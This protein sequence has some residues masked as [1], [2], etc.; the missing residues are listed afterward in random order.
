[1][2]N[3]YEIPQGSL[4][5]YFSNLVKQNGGINLA[6]GI[7]GYKPPEELTDILS[8][9]AKKDIHQYAP[10][11]GN[12]K[13]LELISVMDNKPVKNILIVQGATEA[14]VLIY[15]YLS[16]K[17]DKFNVMSFDP[18][19]ESYINL[20]KIFNH[21]YYSF[22]YDDNYNIDVEKLEKSIKQNN[23]KLLMISSPGNPFGKAYQKDLIKNILTLAEKYDFY[24][25]FDAVYRDLYFNNVPYNP[26]ELNSN[27]LFYINSFSKMFSITGWRIGYLIADDKHIKNI[28]SIHDYIGLCA[29][30]VLQESIA[31]YISEF[32]FGKKYLTN[33]RKKLTESFQTLSKSLIN[34]GFKIPETDGGYFIW[35]KLTDIYPDG[36]SFAMDLYNTQK[37]ACIPGIHFSQNGKK[38]I[39]WNIARE[40][41]EIQEAINRINSFIIK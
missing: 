21:N 20:P 29:P 41:D 37:V 10:G 7:P 12:A 34:H 40:I 14:I 2:K 8:K 9:I 15:I 36:F 38:L 31:N 17:F 4:I 16:Q 18:A 24:I 22:N 13:L 39:R 3:K 33:L 6:Q 1:M 23:I 30:S 19:Y 28:E 26:L 32:D 25:L 35:S 5:S 11:K 27:R